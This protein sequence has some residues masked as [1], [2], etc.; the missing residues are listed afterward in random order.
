MPLN[1]PTVWGG[2]AAAAGLTSILEL[3]VIYYFGDKDKVLSY[4]IDSG[5]WKLEQLKS[6]EIEANIILF[7][8]YA[9]SVSN[10]EGD[11]FIG[12]G[13]VSNQLLKVNCNNNY[14]ITELKPML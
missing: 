12:G 8:Y 2:V 5:S 7:P 10:G 6:P 11:V 13:G 9:S 1:L 4:E 3:P 14:Q